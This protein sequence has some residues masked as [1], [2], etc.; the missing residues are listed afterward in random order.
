MKKVAIVLLLSI[1]V[2]SAYVVNAD[3]PKEKKEGK[4]TILNSDSFDNFI[5]KGVVVVDFW[6]TWCAPCRLQG[7]IV[8][9]LSKE[10]KK[11]KFG[12]LD[13]DHNRQVAMKYGIRGI[14]T[15]IIFKDGKVVEK[16]VGLHQKEDL[17]KIIETHL[18]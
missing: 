4:V 12:K 1:G 8:E 14:P 7:P 5:K 15:L 17:K 16:V 9:D 2:L 18:K 11:V 13:V 10:M 3:G 6:A